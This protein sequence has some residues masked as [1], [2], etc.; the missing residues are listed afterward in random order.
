[1]NNTSDINDNFVI[2][3][4][5]LSDVSCTSCASVI[6]RHFTK[7]D[8]ITVSI[9]FATKK[10][11]FSYDPKFWNEKKLKKQCII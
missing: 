7:E 6:E 8:G 3:R 11:Q 10:A 5:V 2:S 9:N 4:A 1:M